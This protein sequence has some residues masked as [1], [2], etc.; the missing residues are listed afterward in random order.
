MG[1]RSSLI[2]LILLIQFRLNQVPTTKTGIKSSPEISA[3]DPGTKQ[4]VVVKSR[5][6]EERDPGKRKSLVDYKTK[7]FVHKQKT[8][9]KSVNTS[10][11]TPPTFSNKSESFPLQDTVVHYVRCVSRPPRSEVTREWLSKPK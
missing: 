7:L 11:F 5:E 9:R 3:F 2:S 4:F 10:A 8:K 1:S 6:L